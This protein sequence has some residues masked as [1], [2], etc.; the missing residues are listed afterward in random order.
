M[1]CEQVRSSC[2]AV[3]GAAAWVSIDG[4]RLVD[5]ARVADADIGSPAMPPVRFDED[6]A[7]RVIAGNAV[8]FGSGY[9]DVVR[10]EPGLSGARTMQMRLHRYLDRTGPLDAQ[11]LRSITPVDCSQIFGQE[12]DGGALEELMVRFASALN[13][14]GRFVHAGGGNARSV[15]DAAGSSAV[16]L[17]EMLTEMPYYRDVDKYSGVE[18]AFFKRAQITPADLARDGLW[19]FEDLDRLTAFADNLVPHVLRVDGV[20]V[21]DHDLAR[22]IDTRQLLEPGSP[23]EVELRA[24][25][26]VAVD[27]IVASIGRR[28]VGALHV[29]QW[30]W[31]RGGRPRY[32]AIPRPRARSVFY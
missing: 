17:A 30:L 27:R 12:L 28:N 22:R 32:K 2:A 24:A 31:E 14:L 19:R 16:V 23:E 11:R 5:L 1:L 29:D 6:R 15:L 3:V 8:N 20:L 10:K 26:V 21:L 13:D 7:M 4:D 25:A 18:V 9:H